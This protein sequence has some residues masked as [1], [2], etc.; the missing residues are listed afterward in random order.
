MKVLGG[1]N[2]SYF[3]NKFALANGTLSL[4][5]SEIIWEGVRYHGSWQ[6]RQVFHH[7]NK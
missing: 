3:Y 7:K 5:G 1:E 2:K 4:I 6:R